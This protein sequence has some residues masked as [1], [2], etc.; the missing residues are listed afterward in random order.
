MS[1]NGRWGSHS[2]APLGRREAEDRGSAVR[3]CSAAFQGAGSGGGARFGVERKGKERERE[4]AKQNGEERAAEESSAGEELRAGALAWAA[5]RRVAIVAE[6]QHSSMGTARA[7]EHLNAGAGSTAGTGTRG[8]AGRRGSAGAA[9]RRALVARV[10]AGGSER[11]PGAC[12]LE[13]GSAARRSEAAASS[14]QRHSERTRGRAQVPA[15]AER[16]GSARER[17]KGER[18]GVEREKKSQ[19]FDSVQTQD[20]QLKLE[21]F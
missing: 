2:R 11:G 7:G 6:C 15:R 4:V 21:K 5:A 20:F 8:V 16:G 13:R 19:R 14:W 18:K 17:E 12:A 10:R 9:P 1:T 3:W